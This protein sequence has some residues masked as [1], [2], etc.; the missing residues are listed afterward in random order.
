MNRHA[1]E[2]YRSLQDSGVK[3]GKENIGVRYNAGGESET[4][5]HSV[6]KNLAAHVA[7]LNG[8][9][10][11]SEV[12]VVKNKTTVGE[13]DVLIWAHPERLTYAVELENSPKEGVASE[14]LEKYVQGTAIQDM[15][16]LNLNDCPM[17]M[18]EASGWVADELG[19]EI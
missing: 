2:E 13:I 10:V 1:Y 6:C 12:E 7:L 3:V 19:L 5:P 8:Y 14:K 9:R 4:F 18:I 15:L 17:H 16:L 11:D